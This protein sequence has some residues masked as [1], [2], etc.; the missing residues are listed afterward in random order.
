MRISTKGRHAVM[1]MVDIARNGREKPVALAEIAQRQGISLSYLEQLMALMKSE[2]L[3]K[4]VRGPGGGY[5]L[6]SPSESIV[7]NDIVIAVDDHTPRVRVDDPAKATG[8][9][10]TDLLWQA[11]GDEISSYLKT[12]TLADVEGC[13]LCTTS[14]NRLDMEGGRIGRDEPVQASGGA[15]YHHA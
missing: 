9:E 3:V 7:I 6:N 4:S 12:I 15:Y 14:A 1:A 10:L 8:R 5:L 13:T 11:I 2:G